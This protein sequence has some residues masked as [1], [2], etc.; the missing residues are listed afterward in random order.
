MSY[1]HN[2]ITI[3][4]KPTV[5]SDSIKQLL[6]FLINNKT[7]ITSTLAVFASS[8]NLT[9]PREDVLNAMSPD[10]RDYYL[11]NYAYS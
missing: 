2:Q 4:C 10:T 6:Q 11:K 1:R 5:Q 8:T 9:K 7:G 3:S